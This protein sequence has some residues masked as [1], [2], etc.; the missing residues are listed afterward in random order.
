MGKGV[1]ISKGLAETMIKLG[2]LEKKVE[3]P[4][5]PQVPQPLPWNTCCI[6]GCHR[7]LSML[8]FDK[9]DWIEIGGQRKIVCLSCIEKIRR[10]P[11]T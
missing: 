10:H 6:P 11:Q 7:T 1:K 4:K 9:Y 2:V 8:N 5:P 3:P